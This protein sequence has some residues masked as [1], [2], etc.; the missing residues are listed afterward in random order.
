MRWF[1]WSLDGIASDLAVSVDM[2]KTHVRAIYGKLGVNNRRSA[3]VV[4]R[5]HGLT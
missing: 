5:Q 1:S 3:V 4:A 2:V